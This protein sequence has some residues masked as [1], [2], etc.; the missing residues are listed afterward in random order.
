[1]D[2]EKIIATVSEVVNNDLIYKDGLTLLYELESNRH[3]QLDEELYI[4]MQGNLNGFEHQDLIEIEM[5]GV[6]LKFIKKGSKVVY[7]DLD[8]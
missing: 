3:K 2:Y 4:K 5:G 6:L 1:M 7:E 8:N